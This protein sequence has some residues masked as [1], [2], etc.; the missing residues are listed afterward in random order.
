ME[1]LLQYLPDYGICDNQSH[2]HNAIAYSV[3]GMMNVSIQYRHLKA[4]FYLFYM[5]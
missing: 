1:C 5:D 2:P 3:N 4:M